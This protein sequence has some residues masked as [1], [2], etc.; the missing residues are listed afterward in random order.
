MICSSDQ[1]C[2]EDMATPMAQDSDDGLR[3]TL[4]LWQVVL[5]GMGVTIGAGIYVLVG[6]AAGRSGYFAP[7]AFLIA[8]AL[9]SFTALSFAE[10]GTRL[11]VAA[12]EAAY[13]DAGFQRKWLTLATGLFVVTTAAVSAATVSVGAAGY[14]AVFWPAPQPILILVVVLGMGAIACLTTAQ[15]VTLAGIMT[16]IEIGGLLA[17]VAAGLWN[18]DQLGDAFQETPVAMRD[19]PWAGLVATSLIAVFA[20]IGF[21]HV[22]NIAEEIRDPRHT[23]PKALFITLAMTAFLYASVVFI[24]VSAIPPQELAVANAPLARVYERLTGHPLGMMSA[25]AVIATLNGII[26]HMIMISRVLYGMARTGVLAAGLGHVHP[27]TRT[28]LRATGLAIVVILTLA[29]AFPLEKLALMTAQGTLV[30]FFL[31]NA[32]LAR[33]RHKE[34]G[35]P[36]HIFQAPAWAPY[37]GMAATFFLLIASIW[38]SS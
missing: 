14:L 7:L 25:I 15:S 30:I 2:R 33:I 29:L 24:A 37:A 35:R 32:A 21:E 23:L 38:R 20:F 19:V 6:V 34:R 36:S 5:Y 27:R 10:L 22:V 4:S 3:R 11:P 18:A 13:V 9:L 1:R 12:S 28:P 26:V 8:A 17:I 16:T 31:V